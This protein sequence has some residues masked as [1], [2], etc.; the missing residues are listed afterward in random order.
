[1][2]LCKKMTE[3]VALTTVA[4]V[5]LANVHLRMVKHQRSMGFMFSS[6][7]KLKETYYIREYSAQ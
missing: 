3:D 6:I 2:L 5:D 4:Q 1:M 7:E